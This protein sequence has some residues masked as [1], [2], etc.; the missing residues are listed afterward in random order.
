MLCTPYH[1]LSALAYSKLCPFSVKW[2]K[3]QVA[4]HYPRFLYVW[5]NL[6]KGVERADVFRCVQGS[7]G[8]LFKKISLLTLPRWDCSY[9]TF[10]LSEIF[11]EC[12]PAIALKASICSFP[13]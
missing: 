7:G 10:F 6:R 9:Y 11:P 12:D 4:Q 5:D 2:C 3:M 1:I 8:K 13:Y